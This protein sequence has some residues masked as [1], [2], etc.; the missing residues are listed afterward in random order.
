MTKVSVIVPI[1]NVGEYLEACLDSLVQ[2]T[3]DDYEIILVDDGSTDDSGVIAQRYA[4]EYPFVSCHHIENGG[5]GHAR[6]YGV[7]F[8]HG[9]YICFADS[10]DVIPSY[11]YEEMYELGE[12]N[13][14][15]MVIGDVKRFNSRRSY[16]SSLHRRAFRNA[17]EVMHITKNPDLLYDTTSWN[18]LF[19]KDFYDRN[20][21]QWTEG[22][23]YEDLPVSTRAHYL[24]NNVSYLNKIVYKWRARDGASASITQRRD[25]IENFLDRFK[26][27]T[28]IDEF[29]DK[30]VTEPELHEAKDEKWLSLDLRMYVNCL[31]SVDED[32]QRTVIDML[33]DY[34]P[35]V[36]DQAFANIRAIDRLKYH[37]IRRHDLES[38][39]KVLK[40]EK[41]GMKTLRVKYDR[42]DGQYYGNYPFGEDKSLYRMT[43]ELERSGLYQKLRYVRLDEESLMVTGRMYSRLLDVKHRGDVDVE[44]FLVDANGEQVMP[45]TVEMERNGK[46]HTYN[47]SRDYRRIVRRTNAFRGY[48][49]FI[50]ADALADLEDGEYCI[51]CR[52]QTAHMDFGFQKVG[53]PEAGDGPRPY[54]IRLGDKAVSVGYDLN[55]NL[56]IT[57]TTCENE[58]TDVEPVNEHTVRLLFSDGSAEVREFEESLESWT[59]FPERYLNTTPRFKRCG[60]G[61]LY[62]VANREGRLGVKLLREG[63]LTRSSA[64][65]GNVAT[66]VLDDLGE[67]RSI[68]GVNLVGRRFGVNVPVPFT[69]EDGEAAGVHTITVTIDFGDEQQT[70]LLR[71]DTYEL[72]VKGHNAQGSCVYV[73]YNTGDKRDFFDKRWVSGYRYMLATRATRFHVIVK[74]SAD[75]LDRTK[76]SR[77]LVVKY[78]YPLMRLLPIKKNWIVFESSWGA[79]TDCNPGAMYEYMAKNHPEYTCIWSLNDPRIALDGNA[80]RVVKRSAAYYYALARTKYLINNVNFV[81]SYEKRNGQ[82][83]IQTMHGTPLKTLGLDVPGELSTPEAVDRFLRRCGRWDYLV[84]QSSRAEEIT[85]SC[86]AYQKDYLRTGY[87]RND[88]LFQMRNDED[89]ADLKRKYGVDPHRK[90]VLYAPT[91]RRRGRFDLELDFAKIADQLGPEYQLG[92]RVHQF[93]ASGFNEEDLDSRVINLSNVKSMEELFL[94]SDMVITDYSSLMFDYAVLNRP[95][96]FYVYDLEEYRDHLRGFNIDLESEAPGPLLFTTDE[97]ID[98]IRRSDEVEQQYRGAYQTFRE[99][100]CTYETG[101]A[102]EQIYKQVFE[103]R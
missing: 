53:K 24:A 36:S 75:K 42:S 63:V 92:L 39:L 82:I 83:E 16:S 88:I 12:K 19:R 77:R 79:K 32:Y 7:R 44:A 66:I 59:S 101:H 17:T 102:C 50:E 97:V 58:V 65:V 26:A 30:Y 52:Y 80:R 8:A 69:V 14:S 74:R 6:N 95:L 18:K 40:F 93:A 90:L 94:I 84:V 89:I 1:Y 38:L 43:S 61:L 31:G 60:D 25:E 67:L 73:A 13:H 98:A 85:K 70:A 27:V 3:I 48:R 55:Y 46:K 51:E 47:L 41:R 87:P 4:D 45:I 57:V 21:F 5:L 91:W 49:M 78:L 35:R 100:Y 33:A 56:R 64:F 37:Y 81:D 15:D 20:A 76:R 23:L 72:H 71:D 103:K 22:A 86:Y 99:R 28:M 9:E 29:F 62:Y 10:D 34:L 96:L 11:A 2:Q 54:A 68:D